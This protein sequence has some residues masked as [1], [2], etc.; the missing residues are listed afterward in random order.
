MVRGKFLFFGIS[1]LLLF[2]QPV[3]AALD[4]FGSFEEEEDLHEINGTEA[5][6][7][8]TSDYFPAWGR[9]SL[10][11]EFPSTGGSLTL[12]AVPADWRR[13]GSLLLYIWKDEEGGVEIIV[14]DQGGG[15]SAKHFDLSPGVNHLQIPVG[16]L[17]DL[18]LQAIESVS[19]ASEGGQR[20]YLDYVALDRFHPVLTEKGRWDVDYSLDLETPHVKWARPLK[21]GP[22]KSYSVAPVRDGRGIVELA[23]RLDLDF[24]MA[25]LGRSAGIN[26]WGFGDFYVQR[27]PGGEFWDAAYSLAHA[28]LATDLLYGPDYDVIV[29]PG[30][31]P[32]HSYPAE[33]RSNII[34]R[35]REGAGL[36][37][38]LPY[39]GEAAEEELGE[40][41]PLVDLSAQSSTDGLDTSVWRKAAEH[42]ITRGVDLDLFPWGHIGVV[43]SSAAG[44]TLLETEKGNPVLAVK[45][46]GQGR[47]V[48]FSY[49]DT[50]LLP[51]VDNIWSSDLTYPY[52]E[53][54][55]TLVARSV[56]WAAGREPSSSIE[57][58]RNAGQSVEF[59][60]SLDGDG[61][62]FLQIK[63]S[64]G[65]SEYEE[66]REISSDANSAVFTFPSSLSGGMHSVEA[67]LSV[68]G[69]AVDWATQ[70]LDLPA[71]ASIQ[72]VESAADRVKLGE[73]VNGSVA[74]SSRRDGEYRLRIRL[75]DNYSRL[76]D[77]VEPSSQCAAECEIAFDL[78][79]T[80]ALSHLAYID[81]ELFRGD[82]RLDRARQEVFVLQPR[83]WN[84]YD[85]TMYRF[86]VDPMPGTW[87]V[88]DSQLRK[89]NVTTL[90]AYSLE[91]SRHAN[92]NIQAQTRIT[93]VE[94]PDGPARDYYLKMKSDYVRTRDKSLLVREYCFNDPAY[95]E[96]IR[97]E[98]KEMLFDWVP[99]SPLSYYIYE[100]PS[101]T[102]YGD[103][104]DICFSRHC[105]SR[106]RLWLKDQYGSLDALNFQWGTDFATWDEV[107]PDDTYEAQRRGN[108]ASWADHRTFMEHTYAE[109]FRSVLE[110]LRKYDSQG[111]VLNSGTQ[112]SGAHN[113]TDYSRMNLYTEHLNAY[114]G[115]NQLDF[116]R[117]FNPN[118]KISGGAG[119]GVLGKDVLFNFYSNLFKGAN[120]GSYI[121]WEYS[122]LNPDLRLCQSGKDMQ[123]GFEELRGQGIG[124]LVGTGTPENNGIAI[125]YSYPSIHG[126]WIVD[127]E[128]QER[129]TYHASET[130]DHYQANRDGWVTILR[131]S[132]LQFDFIA[133]SDIEEG[134]LIKKGY[135]TL[136]LPMSLALSDREVEQIRAFVQQGGIVIADALPA[137]MDGHTTFR[138]PRELADV[139]G[140]E[141]HQV[142]RDD[143]VAMSGEPTLSL[144]GASALA[145]RDG[146]PAVL[147]NR[148]GD[149]QAFL[150][151][152]F[153]HE[154][155][156]DKLEGRNEDDLNRM[157]TL[158]DAA[159]IGPTVKITRQDG[160]AV[161]DVSSYLF[162]NGSTILLGLVP[163]QEKSAAEEIKVQLEEEV[164]IYDVRSRRYIGSGR[165]FEPTA[166]PSIPELYALV[167]G[168][169]KGLQVQ[170]A[171]STQKGEE[172]TL[173]FQIEGV[174]D[175]RS[176]AV[177]EVR[178]PDGE[179]VDHYGG[180]RDINSGEGAFSFRPALND[181]DGEW[182]VEITD[183]ISGVSER[184]DIAVQ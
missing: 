96:Q 163:D 77:H 81:V 118:L 74:L 45:N 29:W 109:H 159:G 4:V 161:E 43:P 67:R 19:L 47:V 179:V 30:I 49:P 138:S 178:S 173:S 42:Y 115:G 17:N 98:L 76:L 89:M 46:V 144:T 27:S 171:S 177:V 125:H 50:G 93:G 18:D 119:Y 123:A 1:L 142:S 25:T 16:Q 61:E 91:H 58:I 131:D 111:I 32:W 35:V 63:D 72:S 168:R 146:R 86:G 182:T 34:R 137:V 156:E 75:F 155:P 157:K 181:P 164:S 108:Y 103:S 101:L 114:T 167:K 80:G 53:Y 143:V 94:S 21:G 66:R 105:M 117:S 84:D 151:N 95:Q 172:I 44:E 20:F 5:V 8:S 169:V 113:G 59:A 23:Q 60:L 41:S 130:F 2:S 152:Y 11:V 39:T 170:G 128:I 160:T 52:H 3:M 145:D 99:F 51:H 141:A 107:I 28:Y 15:R 85:I 87:P 88:I 7:F 70:R 104:V 147:H 166:E 79:S 150:L 139:F 149:G 106:M 92:Y 12:E 120:A 97:Q 153:L 165:S 37:L 38:L 121:F 22:I 31:H 24:D 135:R 122:T 36:V 90:A 132:G 9:R 116:H 126:S 124:R 13:Q 26:K 154:Y 62:L 78:D 148:F 110:E 176:V 184:V 57:E 14:A 174:S 100:E 127:G 83:N 55:W 65:R 140:I 64:F 158:L 82:R 71:S 183:T 69:E 175:Y 54:L 134:E 102:C 73:R 162:N 56:V 48:A 133:Y 33:I 129:V 10:E 136:V 40:L 112:I 68:N 6:R 180:N